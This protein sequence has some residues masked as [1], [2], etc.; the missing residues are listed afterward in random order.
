MTICYIKLLINVII[1]LDKLTTITCQLKKTLF[2]IIL[3]GIS[4]PN[5]ITILYLIRPFQW[6]SNIMIVLVSFSQ[7]YTFF[8]L[9]CN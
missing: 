8:W 5:I 4:Q 1:P 9:T 7:I 3:V 2:F 6:I